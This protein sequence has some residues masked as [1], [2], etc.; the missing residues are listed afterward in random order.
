MPPNKSI[1]FVIRTANFFLDQ[2]VPLLRWILFPFNWLTQ[3]LEGFRQL[4]WLLSN[5]Y[6]KRRLGACGKGVRIYGRFRV[7]GPQ[8]LYLGNNVHI[9]DNSFIRAEG[10]LKIGDHTHI[11]RNV[12][13]YTMNHDYEGERLPYDEKKVLKSVEIGRNVW[14]GMNVSIVPGVIIGDGAIIGMGAVVAQNVPPL[15]VIGSQPT[16]MLKARNVEHYDTLER[17][18]AYSGMSGYPWESKTHK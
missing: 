4:I 1:P 13:I 2:V 8:N 6:T 11:S 17:E 7:S 5:E 15:A 14:I 3:L 12:V 18:A 9:N 10:G 16:R